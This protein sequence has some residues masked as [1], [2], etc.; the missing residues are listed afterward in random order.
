MQ[1]LNMFNMPS[2]ELS[3]EKIFFT[4]LTELKIVCTV[5]TVCRI[6]DEEGGGG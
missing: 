5:L 2:T 4:V 1:L 6:P 3:R